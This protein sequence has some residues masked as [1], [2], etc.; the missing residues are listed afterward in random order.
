MPS[1]G[2]LRYQHPVEA[3]VLSAWRSRY[4]ATNLDK[5]SHL[6]G[7]NPQ[8]AIPVQEGEDDEPGLESESILTGRPQERPHPLFDIVSVC[9]KQLERHLYRVLQARLTAQLQKSASLTQGMLS[10]ARSC[11]GFPAF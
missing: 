9:E 4:Q 2:Y 10:S 8:L 11:L 5:D 1:V 6:K 3:E 7:P